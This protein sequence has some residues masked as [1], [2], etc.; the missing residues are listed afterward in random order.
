M[1][2]SWLCNV[3]V[4]SGGGYFN[5]VS[6]LDDMSAFETNHRCPVRVAGT[7]R[8][9]RLTLVG[10]ITATPGQSRTFT[11]RKNGIDTSLTITIVG[12]GAT[13]GSDLAHSVTV[14]PGDHLS[15]HQTTLFTPTSTQMYCRLDFEPADGVSQI[16]GSG[17]GGQQLD[18]TTRYRPLLSGETGR[19]DL[20]EAANAS[21][22]GVNGT[23][24]DLDVRS[25]AAPGT[26]KS[27]TF[28]ILKNAVVQDGTGGTVDT[29][30]TIANAA[31]TGT[32][33][34][35]LPIVA[36]D[37][38]S[39]SCA[40]AGSPVNTSLTNSVVFVPDTPGEQILTLSEIASL[41][42]S[43]SAVYNT[44]HG[45][46]K[47]WLNLRRQAGGRTAISLQHI[48]ATVSVAPGVGKSWTF[49]L[50][51]N[52]ADTLLVT[53]IADLATENA[54]A[55]DDIVLIGDGDT[56]RIKVEVS[57][58][59][60]PF[61]FAK[62]TFF[63]F[64]VTPILG[65]AVFGAYTTVKA[66]LAIAMGLDGDT[67]I[68]DTANTLTVYGD[69]VVSGSSS[70]AGEGVATEDWVLDQLSHLVPGAAEAQG[71]FL[72]S[73][74]QIAWESAYT[75]RV[76]AATYAI[77]GH[78]YSSIEDVVTLDAADATLDRIDVIAV[79]TS[80]AA[81]VI[82]GT[83][84]ATPSEPDTD[85]SS[86]VKLGIV[87]VPAASSSAS[88]TST[89]L[90]AENLGSGSGEWNWST[91][92][93]GFTLASTTAPRTGTKAIAGTAVTNGAYAQ[94]QIGAGSVDPATLTSLILYIQSTGT[95]G[96]NRILRVGL[97]S[98]GVLKGSLVS[99]VTGFL[100]FNSAVIGTYQ[101]IAIPIAA[102]AVPVGTTINQVRLT[103]S[104]NG[105]AFG[106]YVDD[107]SFQAGGTSGGS[108]SSGISQSQADAR[109]A[110]R[111]NNLS[112]LASATT[113]RTNL[114]AA[115]N[116]PSY[117]TL[118]T[119]AELTS[120]RVLTAGANITLTDGGAGSTLTIAASSGGG[121]GINE[122][123]GDVT[124][125]PGTGSQA[126]TI[127]NDAVTNAKAANMAD[128]TIK[129]RAVGAGTGDPTDL[130]GTQ[131]TAILNAMVG[132]SGAGGTKGLVPA[133]AAGDAAAAKFLKADGTF[134]VP[135]GTGLN[136]LTGDVTAGPGTGSQAA[137][138]ANDA[139]TYAKIQ[140]AAANTVIARAASSSGD[141]G[142][143]ALA[144]SRLLGRG[145]TGDVAAL[146]LG[147]GL[148]LSGTTLSTVGGTGGSGNIV[149]T[150]NL[151]SEPGSPNAGDLY[152]PDNAF[153]VERY[154]GS[155]WAPW[156][157]IFPLTDPTLAGLST[158]V[159]QGSSTVTSANGGITLNGAATGTGANLVLRV[160]T[161]PSTPYTITALFIPAFNSLKPFIS[162]GLC[163]RDSAS[164]KIVTFD[165]LGASTVSLGNTIRSSKF[166]SATAFSADYF[167]RQANTA[168]GLWLRI[169]D[170]GSF[171]TVSVGYDGVNFT[172]LG[173][174]THA[175][176]I[177]PNQVGIVVGTENSAAPNWNAI[178]TLLSWKET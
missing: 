149:S 94:G 131:A 108:G 89:V 79:D 90:Y 121:S 25:S 158:W 67:H 72:I 54:Y 24:T 170:D 156:G 29:T 92:G 22:C 113:G 175:D 118:G 34:F 7:I 98:G 172:A 160:K 106:F 31:T 133:P 103:G 97:Y 52:D 117:L 37:V 81:V 85:P 70:I 38:L 162:W 157:P 96:N 56:F 99:I 124:A 19:N 2:H 137:T 6:S 128:S 74:G 173:S 5:P 164:G 146:S 101:Q 71:T 83:P 111:A 123:T 32:A 105:G 143:V 100:G 126:A 46:N 132:D 28:H 122:L 64:T 107:V 23:I 119:N 57:G 86:Q 78:L 144:A 77:A 168:G 42:T 84:S 45:A 49:T 10:A 177:T 169:A 166:N 102:F 61:S 104:G 154:S 142:E 68:D 159:N 36:G 138:I 135:A 26:G 76:S 88:V 163:W 30:V 95:W 20:T 136:Q 171:R 80:G 55:P 12:S 75:F 167:S 60:A 33:N 14:A 1:I 116:T 62:V 13:D 17:G 51:K 110:Q 109:Y 114:A 130:T 153:L 127:A 147:T 115:P 47:G 41:P 176:F 125:G 66:P 155:A 82:T 44:P 120:E 145:S 178:T 21:L 148:Q 8:N 87:L 140:N 151:G 91:S 112:D 16:Y 35:S 50:Q 152:F 9:W 93:S 174:T 59:P 43:G 39:L 69:L 18:A 11:L 141:V 165:V 150:G 73:G 40:S 58:T 134:A 53:T 65:S 3:A 63:P 4:L 129:G 27:R 48:H 161:V 139:V 15:V